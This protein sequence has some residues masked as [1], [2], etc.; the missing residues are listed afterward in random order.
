VLDL[1]ACNE[2]VIRLASQSCLI[3]IHEPHALPNKGF[4]VVTETISGVRV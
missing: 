1:A 3:K 2:S 4:V